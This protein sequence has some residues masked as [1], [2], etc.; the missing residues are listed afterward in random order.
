MTTLQTLTDEILRLTPR[1]GYEVELLRSDVLS[2]S[3][4][5]TTDLRQDI[6]HFQPPAAEKPGVP[7][8]ITGTAT[9]TIETPPESNKPDVLSKLE[10]LATVRARLEDVIRIFGDAMAWPLHDS[11]EEPKLESNN[12]NPPLENAFGVPVPP[13]TPSPIRALESSNKTQKKKSSANPIE[14]ILYLLSCDDLPAASEKI[15]ELKELAKIFEGTVEG[16]A[17]I[18]VV[19]ALE[20]K[21]AEEEEKK[22]ASKRQQERRQEAAMGREEEKRKVDEEAE[23]ADSHGW[24]GGRDGYYGLI[25]QLSRMRGGMT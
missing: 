8:D 4:T 21:V 14:E 11:P 25:N 17:R 1:L 23:K 2:L 5:L 9:T 16:P 12:L 15:R 6:E 7:T 22:L 18:A 19:E 3:T 20:S 24:S 10:M 13:R